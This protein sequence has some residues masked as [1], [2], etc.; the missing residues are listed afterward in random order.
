M[1]SQFWD[2]DPPVLDEGP[3]FQSKPQCQAFVG[4]VETFTKAFIDHG[5][6]LSDLHLSCWI[7]KLWPVW[8]LI[9][10]CASDYE[11]RIS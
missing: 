10:K 8:G 3:K 4:T 6:S 2:G 5:R 7:G 11:L 1:Q 9:R